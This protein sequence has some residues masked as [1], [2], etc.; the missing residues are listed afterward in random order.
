MRELTEA[1]WNESFDK[2]AENL[3]TKKD[4]TRIVAEPGKQEL[5]ITRVFNAPREVVFKA[6]TD[7]K[8][9][10]QWWGP[11]RFTTTVKKMEVRPGGSW[12]FVQRDADGNE[13]AFHG[14]YHDILSPNLI[15]ATFEFEGMPG[16]VQLETA[17]FDQIGDK[18]KLTARSVFQSVED[19]DGELKAGMEEGVIETMDRLAELLEYAKTK[20]RAA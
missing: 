9:I 1:G 8:R 15:V 17:V 5:V 20:K 6:Y 18:T 14:V 10:P 19:R 4:L 7:P 12:R 13:Y 16:H 3:K 2:L 11:K